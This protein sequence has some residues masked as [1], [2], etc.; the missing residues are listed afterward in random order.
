LPSILERPGTAEAEKPQG[1][2]RDFAD[3]PNWVI[4][5]NNP[6]NKIDPEGLQALAPPVTPPLAAYDC[7][8]IL[9]VLVCAAIN[10]VDNINW[11]SNKDKCKKPC[12][13][14]QPYGVGTVGY[15]YSDSPGHYPVEGPHYLMYVVNQ[16]PNNCKCFWSRISSNAVECPWPGTVPVVPLTP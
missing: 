4:A 1:F 3:E 6:V 9:G 11:G 16:N 2:M 15:R 10:S 12:P 13:P 7:A 8:V 5:N 14:C